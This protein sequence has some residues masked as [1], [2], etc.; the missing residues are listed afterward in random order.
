MKLTKSC[1]CSICDQPLKWW[2]TQS[3]V[4]C[5]VAICKKHTC[6]LRRSRSSVIFSL[7][8]NCA[9]EAVRRRALIQSSQTGELQRITQSLP[10]IT[11]SLPKISLS[12]FSFSGISFSGI[13]ISGIKE[14]QPQ[15]DAQPNPTETD[16]K[17][18]IDTPSDKSEKLL[19][20]VPQRSDTL[21]DKLEKLPVM[22]PQRTDH[23]N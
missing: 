19:V 18:H 3:C 10:R 21:P 12:G 2:S 23:L 15:N 7:C 14:E 17:Q 4:R 22:V 20:P 11:K 6:N 16:Q 9:L 13:S 8:T 5:K 1:A